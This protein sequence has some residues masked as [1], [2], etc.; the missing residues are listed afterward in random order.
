MSQNYGAKNL[1]RC[2]R[3]TYVA[4]GLNMVATVLMVALVLVF[5]RT[6]LG[7]FTDVPAVVELAMARIFWVASFE[8]ISVL[9]EVSSSAMRGYG[10]SMPPAMATLI[11][12]CSVRLIWVWTVFAASPDYVTLM[13]VYPISWAV[14]VVPLLYL[15]V[16][17]MKRIKR[18]FEERALEAEAA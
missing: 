7:L 14:T 18:R 6:M 15:Y 10:Y 11:C 4:T 16:R 1:E 13:I 17:L 8:P 12:V 9:M 3:V 2:K 5:G